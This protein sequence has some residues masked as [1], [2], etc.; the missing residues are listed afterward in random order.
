MENVATSHHRHG[1][2]I[3]W[4]SYMNNED[5]QY[6]VLLLFLLGKECYGTIAGQCSRMQLC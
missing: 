5:W 3:Q 6:S 2:L 1:E 4:W